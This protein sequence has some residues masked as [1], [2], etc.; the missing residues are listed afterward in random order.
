MKWLSHLR[1]FGSI[2]EELRSNFIH[3]FFDIAWWGLYAGATA[4][5]LTIYATRLGAT[6]TQI[7]LLGAL[8]ATIALAVSLPA[9]RLVRRV[10]AW[11][12]SWVAAF[13]SRMGFGLYALLPFFFNAHDQILA[14]IC[15]TVAIAIPATV[16][17]V[18]FSQLFMEAVPAEWR[19]TV[20]GVRN[21]LFSIISFAVT[22]I[23]G[24]ILTHFPFQMAYQ[25][26]FTIGFVGGAATAYHLWSIRPLKE[27]M[28][29]PSAA[30]QTRAMVQ[31]PVS[32]IT[33]RLS[34]LGS[35]LPP[36]NAQGR[37][38][39]RV[40]AIMTLFNLSNNMISPLVPQILVHR[41][42]L[43]DGIISIG[44]AASSMIVFLV[45]LVIGKII[46]RTGN[47]RGTA[48]GW[49]LMAIHAVVLALASTVALYF[50]SVVIASMASGILL[51]SQMNY[52]LENVPDSERPEWLS[53]SNLMG[54]AAL[55]LGSLLG[56]GIA[57]VIGIPAA[58]FSFGAL[59][60]LATF[61]VFR[62]P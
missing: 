58:I 35:L 22:M 57:G 62:M 31:P 44:T 25:M 42:N 3:Y 8:P 19:G 10:S 20:V 51:T 52:N 1:I 11:R 56:P 50:F 2:P 9:G 41:L 33:R 36:M 34:R 28:M 23:C 32:V 55:L 37:R 46:R 5:F 6:A 54:N 49:G 13:I 43:S 59:R 61:F 47:R 12:A 53:W 45:S 15:V 14:I 40:L 18:G 7:G 27:L 60:L 4:A 21:A 39:V 24:Q 16:I 17:G 48:I 38:Y 29:V 30:D 26:V